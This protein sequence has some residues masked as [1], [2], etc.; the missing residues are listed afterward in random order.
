M[1]ARII[2]GSDAPRKCKH[3]F[4]GLS[5]VRV[6]RLLCV[7]AVAACVA[8]SAAAASAQTFYVNQRGG[9]NTNPC[10]KAAPCETIERGIQKAETVV[11]PNTIEVED[12]GTYAGERISLIK[13]TDKGLTINAEPGVEVSDKSGAVV[14]VGPQPETVKLTGFKFSDEAGAGSAIEVGRGGLVLEGDDITETGGPGNAIEIAEGSSLTMK[15]GT[16]EMEGSAGFGVKGVE[17]SSVTLE[18][19]KILNGEQSGDESGGV[20]TSESALSMTGSTVNL[21]SGSPGKQPAIAAEKDE[22]VSLQNDTVSQTNLNALGVSIRNSPLTVNGLAIEMANSSSKQDG[23]GF[24]STV[25]ASTISH[26]TVSGKWAGLGAIVLAT[27]PT[28]STDSNIATSPLALAPAMVYLGSKGGSGLLLQRDVISSPKVTEASLLVEGGEEGTNA[29]LDSSEVLGGLDGIKFEQ[30]EKGASKLTV[31]ASTI[32]ANVR[33]TAEDAPGVNGVFAQAS[34]EPKATTTVVIQGSIVLEKQASIVEAGD[35]G[36]IS[37]SYSAVPSEAQAAGS[38]SGAIACASGTSGN[39]EVSP[40][41]SLFPEPLAGYQLSPAS[42]AVDSVPASAVALPFG[43]PSSTDLAGNPRVVDG[44]G[45]CLAVQDKGAL[46]LQ[47]HSAP[48]P[49]APPAGGGSKPPAP[50]PPALAGLTVSPSALSA[51]SKGA[52]ISKKHKRTFGA[53]VTYTD[54]EAATTTFTVLVKTAGRTQGHSCKKPSRHNKHGKRCTLYVTLGT[55]T[56]TDTAGANSFHFSGRLKGRKL[57]TGS[58]KLVAVASNANGKS[59]PA[60]ATFKIK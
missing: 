12:E 54:S 20:A 14:T 56:H 42:S 60:T 28:T 7:V 4:R 52:T 43:L 15:G 39:T 19:I 29:T 49:P 11:G 37:C 18:G 2:R 1:L 6:V 16:I 55:F 5:M 9:E 47:G 23:L 38:G 59:T 45:D 40:L 22:A 46:E 57:A 21:V 17:G 53:K 24:L 44:N 41:S 27:K 31:S 10:S 50:L 33:G 13:S 34:T 35:T 51:A 36:S 25:A 26:L 8:G 48:C 30:K 3:N 32:D 58:Y